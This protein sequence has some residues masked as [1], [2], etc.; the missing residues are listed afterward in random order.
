MKLDGG[1][2]FHIILRKCGSA[3]LLHRNPATAWPCDVVMETGAGALSIT[4]SQGLVM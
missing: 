1:P 2:Y 3:E 4:A